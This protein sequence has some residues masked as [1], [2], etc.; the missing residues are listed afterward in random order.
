[1]EIH[2]CFGEEWPDGRPKERK[3]IMVQVIPVVARMI[4]EMFSG[5]FTRSFDS[6]SVRLQIS[7]PDIKDNIVAH[8][9]Q[10]Y[11]LLQTHQGHDGWQIPPS[12]NMHIPPALSAQSEGTDTDTPSCNM[13]L[14]AGMV[15]AVLEVRQARSLQKI[16]TPK[17]KTLQSKAPGGV[18]H[19]LLK[20]QVPVIDVSRARGEPAVADA[21]VRSA[22]EHLVTVFVDYL[23]SLSWDDALSVAPVV[24]LLEELPSK[25]NLCTLFGLLLGYPAAYWFDTEKS[26]ENCLS[27]TPLRVTAVSASCSLIAEMPPVRL[28]SFTIPEALWTETQGLMDTWTQDLEDR[29]RQQSVFTRLI[30]AAET[31][32]LPAVAL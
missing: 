28:Y 14:V 5:D 4:Y 27:M 24:H 16:T 10:L 25:W 3:L 31:V 12:A 32:A 6:G 7:T 11:R 8:L 26:A 23:K 22:V 20:N 15:S 30:I 2:L 1:F 17:V 18:V 19:L 21:G 29:F 9:K 13:E